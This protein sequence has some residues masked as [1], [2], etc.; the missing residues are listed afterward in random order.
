M[1]PLP[2]Q[3][4]IHGDFDPVERLGLERKVLSDPAVR[5]NVAASAPMALSRRLTTRTLLEPTR[6]NVGRVLLS[7]LL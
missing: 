1:K 3:T 6:R 2:K 7:Q 5:H 4:S